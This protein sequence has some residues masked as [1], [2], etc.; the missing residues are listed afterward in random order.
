MAVTIQCPNL[1]CR[2]ILQIPDKV[3]GKRI[4]CGKCGSCFIVPAGSQP[5]ATGDAKAP[6]KPAKTP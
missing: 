6:K 5:R 3:R 1:T 2:S 4:R